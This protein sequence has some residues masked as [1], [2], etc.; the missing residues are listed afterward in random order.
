MA[1]NI[2][3]FN[4][5]I[6]KH[7]IAKNN[8]FRMRILVPALLRSEI[9]KEA[10]V[11]TQHLEFYCKSVTLPE[12]DIQTAEVQPQGFGTIVRRPQSLNFPIL[13][14][15]F[16]VDTDLG[17]VKYFHRWAQ[18]IVQFDTSGGVQSDVGGALPFEMNYKQD[19]STTMRV[20]VF[21]PDGA[22][23]YTYDFEG[24]Y[25]VNIGSVE[26]S[27][28]DNDTALSLSVGF[29]F[30]VLKVTGAKDGVPAILGDRDTYSPFASSSQT[31]VQE[32]ITEKSVQDAVQ[33]PEKVREKVLTRRG[34]R[35]PIG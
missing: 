27:W 29:S 7:G 20:D 8:L 12:F 1:F 2:S 31:T 18:H 34:Y 16:N 30:D 33:I 5:S 13:P 28:E 4:A 19:Y 35:Y 22:I 3:E 6:K 21:S 10:P 23:V 32:I 15:V 9:S 26:E 24:A 17:V 14:A 11:A 25:P